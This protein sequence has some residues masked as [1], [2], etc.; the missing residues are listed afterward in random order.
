MSRDY[1]GEMSAV[2]D[3]A[4]GEG[5]YVSPIVAQE[6]VDKLRATDQ[7]LLSGWLDTM[8]THFVHQAINDRDRSHRARARAYAARSAFRDA[9]DAAQRG[10]LD[11]LSRFLTMPFVVADGSRKTLASMTAED[12]EFAAAG[13]ERTETRARLHKTFLRALATKVGD[14]VVGDHFTE[15]ELHRM[16]RSLG[17]GEQA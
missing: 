6:I 4:T 11:P 17:G 9:A 7:E 2:I 8:A 1:I 3:E 13:Y 15:N 10:E 16:W 5:P 14:G 12:L